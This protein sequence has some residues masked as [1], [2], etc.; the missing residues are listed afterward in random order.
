MLIVVYADADSEEA[1]DFWLGI[2]FK[3]II[4]YFRIEQNRLNRERN[5]LETSHHLVAQ[6]RLCFPSSPLSRPIIVGKGQFCALLVQKAGKIAWN[7]GEIHALS[8]SCYAPLNQFR[9]LSGSSRIQKFFPQTP[10]GMDS[11]NVVN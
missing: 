8:P 9:A 5:T 10:P 11:Q 1:A 3:G 6:C 2:S 4:R 7:N